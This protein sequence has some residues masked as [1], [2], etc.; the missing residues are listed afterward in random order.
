MNLLIRRA[1]R[2]ACAPRCAGFFDLASASGAAAFGGRG[3]DRLP[4]S[5]ML[6]LQPSLE[7]K[8]LGRE[9]SAPPFPLFAAADPLR[10]FRGEAPSAR[11]REG[12]WR[13]D[14]PCYARDASAHE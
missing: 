5:A 4:A 9:V 8:G 2:L 13:E 7:W 1:L 11:R 3:A 14:P 10:F 6:H 12:G